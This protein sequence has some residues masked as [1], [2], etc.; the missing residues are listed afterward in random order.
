MTDVV[1]DHR[2]V[3]V[4]LAEVTRITNED[5]EGLYNAIVGEIPDAKYYYKYPGEAVSKGAGM[6]RSVLPGQ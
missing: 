3:G 2:D 5:S 1:S 6:L 4:R